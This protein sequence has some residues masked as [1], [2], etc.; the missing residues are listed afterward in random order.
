M[1]GV[2]V[3]ERMRESQPSL[4]VLFAT[5]D[6]NANG[7]LRDARTAV[8]VKPYGVADLIEAIGRITRVA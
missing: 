8:I 3:A 6:H 5:G 1:S 7:V 4:P 2:E